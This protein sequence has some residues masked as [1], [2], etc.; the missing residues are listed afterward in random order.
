MLDHFKMFASYNAWANVRLYDAVAGLSDTDYRTGKGAFFGSLQATL[1]HILVADRIWMKRFTGLGEAPATLDAVLF[2][3]FS[4]LWNARQ[5]EDHRI[6]EWVASL[7]ENRLAVS[8]TFTPV[9]TPEP[10]TQKLAPTLAHMFNHQTHHRGQAHMTLTALGRPS[11]ALDMSY[12]LR[13]P[14]GAAWA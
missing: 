6:A 5:A 8:F 10:V 12:F 11:L 14:E 9:S 4:G 2:D 1:N 13:S 3:D 7:D